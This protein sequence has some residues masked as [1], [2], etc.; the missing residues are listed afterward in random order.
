[1]KSAY[2]ALWDRLGLVASGACLVHCLAV[3]VLVPLLPLAA[4]VAKAG[5]VHETL[6]VALALLALAA[7]IPGY[8]SHRRWAVVMIGAG[9]VLLLLS[10]V[11]AA[12]LW[13]HAALDTPL[14]VA[15]G[16]LLV[17]AHWF[18]LRLCRA[19]PVCRSERQHGR[20]QDDERIFPVALRQLG[21]GRPRPPDNA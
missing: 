9:G 7:F 18:N 4:G 6:L 21:V 15:G 17:G 1:M 11:L 20:T 16:A 19:C 2:R 13:H 3:P 14:T 12:D 8:R 5:S 10:A